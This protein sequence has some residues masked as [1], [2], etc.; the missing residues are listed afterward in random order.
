MGNAMTQRT[1]APHR[2]AAPDIADEDRPRLVFDY[3]RGIEERQSAQRLRLFES[4]YLY[5]GEELSGVNV[6]WVR[7]APS[8]PELPRINAVQS[9]IETANARIASREPRLA[10]TTRGGDWDL[11]QRAKGLEQ[12]I[13]GTMY[14]MQFADAWQ[15][16]FADAAWGGI[17]LTKVSRLHDAPVADRIFPLEVVVDEAAAH[18]TAPKAMFQR[19]F[20]DV[21]ELAAEYPEHEDAIWAEAS[22]TNIDWVSYMSYG[23]YT[24]PVIE[25]WQKPARPGE[26]GLHL[27]CIGKEILFQEPWEYDYFPIIEIRWMRKVTGWSGIGIPE[28]VHFLQARVNRHEAYVMALQNRA[29]SPIWLVDEGDAGFGEAVTTD[30]GQVA[31]WHGRQE[32]HQVVPQQVPPEIFADEDRKIKQIFQISGMNEFAQGGRARPPTGLDSQPALEMWIEY[33]EGRFGRQEKD[34]DNG[35]VTGAGIVVDITKELAVEKKIPKATWNSPRYGLVELDWSKVDM[36][37]DKFRLRIMPASS[38][39]STPAGLRQRLEEERAAGRMADDLYR[40]FVQT[41]DTEA[42]Y[43][44]YDAAVSDLMRTIS[45]LEQE[46]KPFPA[47]NEYQAL[48][49]GLWLVQMEFNKLHAI[50][51]PANIL[52]RLSLWM[53]QAEYLKSLGQ[54]AQVGTAPQLGPGQAGGGAQAPQLQQLGNIPV[55]GAA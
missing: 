28:I 30:L 46:D 55:P 51:A 8:R 24:V 17:G 42:Y 9:V 45:L 4:A 19:R 43:N 7:A 21:D 41:L 18:S 2:W 15:R 22:T 3:V 11:R 54:G 49:L 48:E 29:V 31:T 12:F 39:S 20:V 47:P 10:V 53:E 23:P 34:Y 14:K 27:V 33:T 6:D 32:P 25:A 36:E 40:Y 5:T 44:L 37:K 50:D 1:L 13:D 35:F 26:A 16:S 38:T 52:R